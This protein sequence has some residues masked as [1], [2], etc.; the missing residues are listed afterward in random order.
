MWSSL[1]V[2]SPGR[3]TAI[4]STLSESDTHDTLLHFSFFEFEVLMIAG[5]VFK[6][7][8][9]VEFVDTQDVKNKINKLSVPLRFILND[10]LVCPSYIYK[11][12]PNEK[13]NYLMFCFLILKN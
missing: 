8:S 2:T 13:R 1:S 11:V 3:S 5:D 10:V 4:R 9:L 6:V 7:K 12:P